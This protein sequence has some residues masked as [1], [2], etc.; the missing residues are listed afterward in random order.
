MGGRWVKWMGGWYKKQE[1]L[2]K[3]NTKGV[4]ITVSS[5][6]SIFANFIFENKIFHT[7]LRFLEKSCRLKN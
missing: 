2:I 5:S 6:V 4:D 1:K 3:T 7:K